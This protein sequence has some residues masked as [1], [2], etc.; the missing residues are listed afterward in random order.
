MDGLSQEK[1]ASCG[2]IPPGAL[3]ASYQQMVEMLHQQA[4]LIELSYEPIF[5]WDLESGIQMWNR[6]CEQLYGFT[7]MEALGRVSHELLRTVFPQSVTVFQTLLLREKQWSGELQHTTRDGRQ[8]IVES[9][10]QLV[11]AGNRWLVLETN[12]DITSRKRAEEVQRQLLERL[13]TAQEEERLRISHELHDQ[14][15]QHLSVLLLGLEAVEGGVQAL[16][17]VGQQIEQLRELTNRLGQEMHHL[18]WTIRPPDLERERLE[19]VLENY[20]EEWSQL[21]GLTADFHSYGFSQQ[22]LPAHIETTLYR[23]VQEALTNVFKHAQAQHVSVLLKHRRDHVLLIVEDNGQGFP[24]E[25]VLSRL[26]E[27][28][29]LG[30]LGMHERLALL[31]GTLD[32]EATPGHGTTIFVRIPFVTL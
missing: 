1:T 22:R 5:V 26:R 31:G 20:I 2:S 23:I 18:A 17:A 28:G 21:C 10:H 32:I 9:R 24:V 13:V 4:L 29:K 16:P 12:R 6:G 15:G 30:L 3:N 14:M 11:E 19:V 7:K 8:V 25:S 27:F